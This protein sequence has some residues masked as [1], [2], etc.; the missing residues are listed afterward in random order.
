MEKISV[1][2]SAN[3][4]HEH[5]YSL[6][7]TETFRRSHEEAGGYVHMWI[8]RLGVRPRVFCEMTD[9]S[10]EDKHLTPWMNVLARKACRNPGRADLDNLHEIVHAVLFEGYD[11]DVSLEDWSN[12]IWN[13]EL[14]ASLE[15]RALVFF[16][17]KDLRAQLEEQKLWVDRFLMPENERL[18]EEDPFQFLQKMSRQQIE[19]A[20]HGTGKIRAIYKSNGKFAQVWAG[21]YREVESE[22]AKFEDATTI[23]REGAAKA[24]LEWL[25]QKKGDKLCPYEAE[26][27]AFTDLLRQAA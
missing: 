1:A 27:R 14:A 16:A 3:E 18:F 4:V 9:R 20:L 7:R 26:A 23:N 2:V 19:T 25:L 5:V 11:P 12:K 15:T 6:W 8:D 24:H 17:L 21:R 22:M 13:N 10:I